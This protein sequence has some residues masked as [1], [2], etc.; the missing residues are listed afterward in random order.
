MRWG[1]EIA[2]PDPRRSIGPTANRRGEIPPSARSPWTK[3]SD[4]AITPLFLSLRPRYGSQIPYLA[5]IS[6]FWPKCLSTMAY[7]PSCRKPLPALL[8]DSRT[9]VVRESY[10]QKGK[11]YGYCSKINKPQRSCRQRTLLHDRGRQDDSVD[12]EVQ[13]SHPQSMGRRKPQPLHRNNPQRGESGTPAP[14]YF[15]A[16]SG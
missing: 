12:R 8:F 2:A 16:R 3:T 7:L 9:K 11:S 13:I 15:P 1:R 5:A 10:E 14:G 4:P 6:T